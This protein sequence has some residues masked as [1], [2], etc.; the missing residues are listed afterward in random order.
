METDARSPALLRDL[1]EQP[2][3]AS[4]GMRLS[5]LPKILQQICHNPEEDLRAY[6]EAFAKDFEAD[7]L[8]TKAKAKK[9]AGKKS[10]KG[11]STKKGRSLRKKVEEYA[12]RLA[13]W[14]SALDRATSWVVETCNGVKDL[15]TLI[16]RSEFGT[17]G[18]SGSA[19]AISFKAPDSVSSSQVKQKFEDA[20]GTLVVIGESFDNTTWA[21]N[22]IQK[23]RTQFVRQASYVRER[24][25]AEKVAARIAAGGA[26]D[27]LESN[28]DTGPGTNDDGSLQFD[29]RYDFDRHGI[30]WHLGRTEIETQKTDGADSE[31]DDEDDEDD[32]KLWKILPHRV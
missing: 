26:P 15:R 30:L 19:G 3:S 11:S 14:S 2:P 10:K 16:S 8:D 29:Y 12:R 20:I 5:S 4:S 24:M 1:S 27:A 25:K 23:L 32:S 28:N 9:K 6:E 21:L 7:Q 18:G 31:G 22:N 17:I 13:A